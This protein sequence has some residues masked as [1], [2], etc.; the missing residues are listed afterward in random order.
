MQADIINIGD[1]LLIGQTVNTNAAWMGKEL[2]NLGINIVRSTTITDERLPILNA[3]NEAIER[4]DLIIITGGLGPTKDDI[5]KE[6][7]ADF[8][9]MELILHE[10]VLTRVKSYFESRGRAMLETNMQQAYL[11]SGCIVLD[12]HLGTASGMWFDYKGKVVVSLP[13]VPYE[14]K[15][16][17]SEEV[18]PRVSAKFSVKGMYY[19]TL[20]TQGIGESF[21]AEKIKEWEDRIYKDGLSLAYLPSPGVVKL[22]LTSKKGS[23]DAVKIDNYFKELESKLP[24]YVY[25]KNG[26]S[27]FDVVSK[28][29]RNSGSTLGTVESCTGGGIA[30]AFVQI[31]GASDF[32]MGSFITYSNE[33]KVGLAGVKPLTLENHG[34]VSEQVVK[35]M[36]SGGRVR[37]GVDYCIAVSGIAG[38]SGGSE[39]K[40]VGTTW[41]AIAS[42]SR[43]IA[44]EFRF[45]TD[46][47]RNLEM[48][49]L[50]AANLLRKEVL[51]ISID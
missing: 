7:L 1:E 10:D 40:P 27:I 17:M 4:S 22:R 3:L 43:T 21:L 31:D 28:L 25:G 35:E 13:G 30:N 6:T 37:L 44:K 41:I 24:K 34:A 46:R 49:A 11:P 39:K 15:A 33:L 8:F 47:K 23:E 38:P 26:E 50:S 2:S 51:S 29:L 45:G 16:L 9:E 42:S 18:L 32:F 12:N 36:A 14:M 5:T 48:T 19:Q 20:M